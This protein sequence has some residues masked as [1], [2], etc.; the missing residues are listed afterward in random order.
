M[1]VVHAGQGIAEC[2]TSGEN[3]LG[4]FVSTLHTKQTNIDSKTSWS[5]PN[6][7]IIFSLVTKQILPGL[8]RKACNIEK[9]GGPTRL[10]TRCWLA[11]NFISAQDNNYLGDQ[12]VYL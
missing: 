5:V 9:L 8:Y 2:E 6:H 12:Y 11:E 4:L 10:P 1:L 7:I 3:T